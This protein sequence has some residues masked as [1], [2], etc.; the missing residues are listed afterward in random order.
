MDAKIRDEGIRKE[1][2][3]N[4]D[5]GNKQYFVCKHAHKKGL[6]NCPHQLCV[7]F[8]WEDESMDVSWNSRNHI[9]ERDATERA[10]RKMDD[11]VRTEIISG[12]HDGL[13]PA[14][15]RMKNRDE[16]LRI[17]SKQVLHK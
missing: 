8:S 12:V 16:R 7:Q 3:K 1:T 9:Y 6:E 17:P 13:K 11:T 10:P 5:D 2:R 15:V 14:Q 4:T